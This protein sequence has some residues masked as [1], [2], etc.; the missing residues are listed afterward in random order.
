M[1]LPFLYFV[2]VWKC[3]LLEYVIEFNDAAVWSWNLLYRTILT[4]DS[5]SLIG[6]DYPGSLFTLFLFL[7]FYFDFVNSFLYFKKSTLLKNNLPI[8]NAPMLIMQVNKF[9][10]MLTLT[11]VCLFLFIRCI[12]T[13]KMWDSSIPKKFL[14]PLPSQS[15]APLLTP[16]SHLSTSCHCTLVFF[17]I[18]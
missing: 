6:V 13:I 8:R 11:N 10:Q 15:S 4:I 7:G 9:W 3:L 5:I 12:P 1:L 2:N 17:R 14:L 18:S 16:G